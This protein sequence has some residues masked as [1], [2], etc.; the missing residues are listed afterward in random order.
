MI[1]IEVTRTQR[2][3]REMEGMLLLVLAIVAFVVQPVEAFGVGDGLAV[4]LF[5]AIGVVALCAL[6]GFIA[7]KLNKS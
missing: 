1:A 3:E 4:V 7:R 5:L 2:R 6:L